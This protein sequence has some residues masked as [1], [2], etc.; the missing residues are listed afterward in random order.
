M[1][2]AGATVTPAVTALSPAKTAEKS[3]APC[4]ACHLRR[5][6]TPLTRSPGGSVT[7]TARVSGICCGTAAFRR[8]AE[9]GV[10]IL[11]HGTP[12]ALV[13]SRIR[14]FKQHPFACSTAWAVAGD[15]AGGVG[16]Q[17]SAGRAGISTSTPRGQ[18][19][20]SN[21]FSGRCT[22]RQAP[23][24]VPNRSSG[25]SADANAGSVVGTSKRGDG[26]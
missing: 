17:A 24:L 8:L 16:F 10:A 9:Q 14:G 7:T 22:G 3:R 20:P 6:D 12:G 4:S 1:L 13:I 19:G 5:G 18:P 23:G 21:G 2:L 25:P 11:G 15:L 26:R